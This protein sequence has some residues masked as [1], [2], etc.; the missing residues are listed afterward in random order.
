MYLDSTASSSTKE[1]PR[2]L[3]A[4]DISSFPLHFLPGRLET[5]LCAHWG[6]GPWEGQRLLQWYQGT[7]CEGR[8]ALASNTVSTDSEFSIPFPFL[9]WL[10]G[11]PELWFQIHQP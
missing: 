4:A 9:T 3:V 2:S 6:H 10:P 8:V 11:N 1:T 5:A 7:I